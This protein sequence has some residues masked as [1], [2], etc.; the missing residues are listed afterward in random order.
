[1]AT[2][3]DPRI[4]L[5]W[6]G[7]D[8]STFESTPL[9]SSGT[10]VTDTMF[11]QLMAGLGL[12]PRPQQR[13]LVKIAL[14]NGEVA[15][16]QSGT[17][18]GK[19]YVILAAALQQALAEGRPAVVVCPTN[20][21]INQYLNKDAPTV[22]SVLGGKFVSVKGRSHYICGSSDGA[23][24][25][26]L[27][28]RRQWWATLTADPDTSLEWSQLNADSTWGCPG[29]DE[30]G[31]NMCGALVARARAESAN[32][33]ITNAHVLMWHYLVFMM[34]DG[35]MGL[36][37][38]W[39]RLYVDECHQLEEIA[40]SCL[41][42]EIRPGSRLY[43]LMP[44]LAVWRDERAEQLRKARQTEMP[45][46]SA[47]DLN[48]FAAR[49]EWMINTLS[50]AQLDRRSRR[51]LSV[52]RK[53]VKFVTEEPES[54]VRVLQLQDDKL[55]LRWISIDAGVALNTMLRWA[56]SVLVSG[57]V[58]ESLPRR[59]GLPGKIHV[60]ELGHPF[61]YAR[62]RLVISN[63]SGAA[64][65]LYDVERARQVA[66]AINQAGGGTLVLF[67]SWRD[68]DTIMPL[69]VNQLDDP[70]ETFVQ[71]RTDSQDTADMIRQFVEHP[72]G[73]LAGVDSLATG[74][75]IAGPAL[76][77]VVI[78]KLPYAVPT[79]EVEAI[80]QRFGYQTY[81]ESMLMKLAQ[82]AGRLVRTK[83]DH[84]TV[85]LVDSRAKAIP[86][87][88]YRVTRHLAEFGRR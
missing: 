71:H 7:Q 77:Q 13:K 55:F 9:M 41:S 47:D 76:R 12:K 69:V 52:L 60:H 40:R 78:W 86:W 35:E 56:P 66:A 16:A 37:P 70:I 18:T 58:P 39:S 3:R 83:D 50:Q 59:L 73:V 74:L 65:G 26:G 8:G 30:C 63:K 34:S 44:E 32:V 57:T 81:K 88:Q 2:D 28:G 24:T 22:Q 21:L 48:A 4:P 67:T 54:A 20:A 75:D 84:G 6:D 53:F 49:A 36:L 31:G 85:F 64:G 19:S 87:S 11:K 80:K 45:L 33:V 51:D 42:I 46:T 23:A 61:D 27:A 14:R 29:S 38:E 72:A 15:I 1:M 82:A 62:S 79:A 25:L 10:P 43:E 17:G 68:L 5:R